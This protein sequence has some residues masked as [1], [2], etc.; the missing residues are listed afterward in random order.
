V[1]AG[2]LLSYPPPGYNRDNGLNERDASCYMA[3]AVALHARRSGAASLAPSTRRATT[4]WAS[5]CRPRRGGLGTCAESAWEM[6]SGGV[7]PQS[8]PEAGAPDRTGGS[9]GRP[10]RNDGRRHRNRPGAA[11]SGRP[12]EAPRN[13]SSAAISQVIRH[14]REPGALRARARPPSDITVSMK[15]FR[16]GPLS[17]GGGL[18]RFSMRLPSRVVA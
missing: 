15:R 10:H 18:V 14:L 16:A 5:P 1:R 9:L 7:R 3:A 8:P 4:P 11:A 2:V 17:G 12:P 6:R 13:S